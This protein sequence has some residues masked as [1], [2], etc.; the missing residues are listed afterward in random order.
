[1]SNKID[2]TEVREGPL[3]T[4]IL[5]G[6]LWATVYGI[7]PERYR[8]HWHFKGISKRIRWRQNRIT[9]DLASKEETIV[10]LDLNCYIHDLPTLVLSLCF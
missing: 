9:F 2:S 3:F 1:M 6:I 8:Y 4:R 7:N 5:Q 10:S